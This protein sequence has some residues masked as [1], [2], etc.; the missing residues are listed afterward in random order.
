MHHPGS[1]VVSLIRSHAPSVLRR[2]HLLEQPGMIAFF[3]PQDIVQPMIVQRLNMRGI[4]TQAIFSDNELEVGVVP[5][6][7]SHE[8]FGGMAFTIIF[9][10]T[11][12]LHNR[13]GHERNDFPPVWVDNR[14]ASHLLMIGHAPVAVDLVET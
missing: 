5:T 9:V 14:G 4:G 7:L 10:C 8:A 1:T 2:L 12:L 3:D 11:I 6:Q 13:L